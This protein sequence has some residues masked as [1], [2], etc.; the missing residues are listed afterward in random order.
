MGALK[1]IHSVA[2]V[3]ATGVRDIFTQVSNVMDRY[4]ELSAYGFHFSA[5]GDWQ[6]IARYKTERERMFGTDF[7]DQ[8][9]TC[10]QAL[11]APRTRR[12][13]LQPERHSSYVLRQGGAK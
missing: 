13:N 9:E 6:D 10:L 2:P 3:P 7:A 12:H 4:P 8:V 5:P 11:L 1:S